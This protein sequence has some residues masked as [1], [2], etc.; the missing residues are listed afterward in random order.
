[1]IAAL[2]ANWFGD[3]LDGTVARVR[4]QQRPRFGFYVDHVIDVAGTAMLLAGM[5]WSGCMEPTLAFV[6]LAAYL[7]VLAESFLATHAARRLPHVVL[8]ASDRPSCAS[9]SGAGALAIM[10]EPYID[11][12]PLAGARLFDVGGVI[13]AVGLL[14]VFVINACRN[15]RL[16][17]HAEPIPATV[18]ARRAA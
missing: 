17:F 6:A 3:S 12:G 1:M 8:R 14:G 10:H 9:S 5:A 18:D 13:A 15:T 2:A 16:L 11:A 4:N 7:M